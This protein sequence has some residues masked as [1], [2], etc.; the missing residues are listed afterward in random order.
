MSIGANQRGTTLLF[1]Q[2]TGIAGFRLTTGSA[3]TY[4]AHAVSIEEFMGDV[5]HGFVPV[6]SNHRLSE[7]NY[8][9]FVPIITVSN[10]KLD[11]SLSAEQTL[12]L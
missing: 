11:N 9:K 10:I 4:P 12:Q 1:T 5:P 7:T 2:Y 8:H 3:S 6:R